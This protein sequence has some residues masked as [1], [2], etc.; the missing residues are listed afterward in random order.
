MPQ[1]SLTWMWQ[2]YGCSTAELVSQVWSEFLAFLSVCP[3]WS[4]IQGAWKFTLQ[5]QYQ[6]CWF[7][8]L[9]HASH[10]LVPGQWRVGEAVQ[11]CGTWTWTW[12]WCKVPYEGHLISCNQSPALKS[13]KKV[14]FT[15]EVLGTRSKTVGTAI[16]LNICYENSTHSARSLLQIWL[17]TNYFHYCLTQ[18]SMFFD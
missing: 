15:W 5:V 3:A 9:W 10:V 11:W 8:E 17:T 18:R 16:I 14:V 6:I 12:T 13:G 1:Y 4:M 2:I 7:P